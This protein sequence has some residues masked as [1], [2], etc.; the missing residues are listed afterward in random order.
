MGSEIINI[1][2]VNLDGLAD[3][4]V[5][6][7]GCLGGRYPSI[8]IHEWDGIKF[9]NLNPDYS[10]CHGLTAPLAV[11]IK[12]MDQN[13]TKEIFLSNSGRPWPDGL[14]Y[15]YRKESLICMWNGQNIV[16]FRSEFG[17]PHFRYQALQNGDAATF[18]GDQNKALIFYQQTIFDEKLEWFTEERG[19][20]DFWIYHAS[21]FPSL[22]EPTPTS[23]PSLQADPR[24]YPSLAAYAYYR[25]LLLHILQ[26]HE[27]DASTVYNALQEKFANDQYGRPYVEMATAFW[28]AYQSTHKMY[29][30]C[31]AAIQYAA[32]HP[33]IL[34]PLGSDYHGSQSHNYKPEDVCPFR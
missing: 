10:R 24:E 34:I 2:D 18:A 5:Y 9:K 13:G 33:E 17:A 3:I 7:G 26:A 22:A 6:F 21:Y 16:R 11:E 31:A 12:D 28:N 14:G 32:E 20:N 30:G 29:D 19:L 4:I 25:I 23:S 15:P 27:S 1:T 8:E